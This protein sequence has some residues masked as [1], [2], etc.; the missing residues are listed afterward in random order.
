MTWR[1]IILMAD[2]ECKE[3]N[4]IDFMRWDSENFVLN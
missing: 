4:D 2:P 1:D 3:I